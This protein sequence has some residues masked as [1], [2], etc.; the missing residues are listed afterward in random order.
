MTWIDDRVLMSL[1]H[2][3]DRPLI[4]PGPDG[5]R[6]RSSLR[7]HDPQRQ[8]QEGQMV[9]DYRE[10]TPLLPARPLLEAKTLCLV[11]SE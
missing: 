8:L 5:P 10:T 4:Q 7:M 9:S 6:S 2:A 11:Q 3:S 1:H